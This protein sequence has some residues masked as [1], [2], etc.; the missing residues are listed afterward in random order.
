M[1][2]LNGTARGGNQHEPDISEQSMR[3]QVS[4]ERIRA[5]ANADQQKHARGPRT[6]KRAELPQGADYPPGWA[7]GAALRPSPSWVGPID[8]ASRGAGAHVGRI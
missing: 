2:N 5:G 1:R 8:S 3:L 6:G 4:G 7:S